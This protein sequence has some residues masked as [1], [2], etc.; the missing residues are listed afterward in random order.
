MTETAEKR[1]EPT[2]GPYWVDANGDDILIEAPDNVPICSVFIPDRT[3]E[4][5]LTNAELLAASWD[6]VAE[7]DRLLAANAELWKALVKI[8][9]ARRFI[10]GMVYSLMPEHL[11]YAEQ[12]IDVATATLKA[13]GPAKE[14]TTTNDF[15]DDRPDA[16]GAVAAG[17]E[18]QK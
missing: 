4:E 7:R 12:T 14:S 9:K 13:H 16:N 10:N 2:P 17:K 1:A 8:S 3:R 18:R 15:G 5:N 11:A 6:T